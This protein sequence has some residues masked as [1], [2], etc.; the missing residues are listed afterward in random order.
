[1]LPFPMKNIRKEPCGGWMMD[2]LIGCISHFFQDGSFL[3]FFLCFNHSVRPCCCGC[4]VN[5]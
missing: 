3:S 1:M 2:V 4:T 5:V